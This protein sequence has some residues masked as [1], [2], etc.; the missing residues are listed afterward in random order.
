[1]L[2]ELQ[3][4]EIHTNDALPRADDPVWGRQDAA[5]AMDERVLWVNVLIRAVGDA[6]QDPEDTW[7]GAFPSRDFR[8]VCILAGVDPLPVWE[9]L[10][11][12]LDGPASKRAE[13]RRRIYEVRMGPINLSVKRERLRELSRIAAGSLPADNTA[14]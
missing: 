13:A 9:T 6:L 3:T 8:E 12:L 2:P 10:R 1:M 5:S 14:D 4:P 11:A 7:V